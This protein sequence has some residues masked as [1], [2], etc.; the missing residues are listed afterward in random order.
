MKTRLF[1]AITA[2][3]LA[4]SIALCLALPLRAEPQAPSY[5]YVLMEGS[6]ATLLYA[7]NGEQQVPAH[8]CAKLMTLLLTARAVEEGRLSLETKLK[9]SPHANSMQGAQIWLMAGEEISVSELILAIT[10]GNANDACVVLAEAV[11]GTEEKFIAMM[12]AAAEQLGMV[13]T[14]YADSTGIS[15]KSVT[16]ACDAAIL[17][18]ELT[19]FDFLRE[20][21]T[22]WITS[23]RGGKTELA[24]TNRLIL[25]YDGLIGTK[26]YYSDALGNC[27]IAAAE[28]DGLIIVCVI[29]GEEDEFKRFT[30]AK[31]KLNAG[32]LAYTLYAPRKKDIITEPVPVAD[33][34]KTEAET[35]LGELTPFI[36]RKSLA[37]KVEVSVEYFPDI[38]AP[39]CEGDKV[40]RAVYSVDGEEVYSCAI[41]AGESVKKMNLLTAIRKILRAVI[42]M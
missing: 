26:A 37:D 39:L 19:K 15:Q 32:F 27:V 8:H 17:A 7:E 24:S 28:R 25:S 13:G 38:K 5:S 41:E 29:F 4:L 11:G 16:T 35:R 34:V 31:E 12:N 30:T 21:L 9:T 22:T 2:L 33:G 6:T 23:V 10:V 3:I 14:F 1:S 40:G 42:K 20:P 18:S 36:I